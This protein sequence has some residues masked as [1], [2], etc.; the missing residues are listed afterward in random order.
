[1]GYIPA[2]D[3]LRALA[4]S[5]VILFHLWPWVLPGGYTGVDIFFVISGFVVTGSMTGRRFETLG[6]FLTYFYARRL[7]RIMPALGA[8]LIAAILATNLFVPDAWLSRSVPQTGIAAFFGLSN[9]A[10]ATD[11]DTYFGPQAGY[12]PFTHTWSLGVE[13]QFYLLFPFLLYPY[14]RLQARI[15]ERRLLWLVGGLTLGSFAIAAILLTQPQRFAFYLIF[16]RFW[17]LGVGMLLCLTLDR[18]RPW[19]GTLGATQRG[20]LM[21]ASLALIGAGLAMPPTGLFPFPLAL[22]P[23]LGTAGLIATV[24]ALPRS[25][26]TRVFGFRPFVVVGQLSY[27][28]YLWHWPVFVL[29][30]WTIGLETLPLALAAL[31]LAIALATL[32]YYFIEQPLRTNSRIA[33]MPRPLVVKGALACVAG[34]GLAGLLIFLLHDRIS[35]SV[36]SDHRAWYAETNRTL[37]PAQTHCRVTE[38]VTSFA[39]GKVTSWTPSQCKMRPAGFSVFA[40]GDSHNTAYAPDYRQLAADLGVTVHSWFRAGC[41]FLRL[42]DAIVAR[43]KCDDYDAALIAEMRAKAKPGDVIFLPGLRVARLINQFVNDHDID[44]A[45]PTSV[46]PQTFAATQ[47]TLAQLAGTGAKIVFEAPKPLFRSPPFRCSDWFNRNNPI[48]R[49][50]LTIARAELEA[51]RRPVLDAM[52]RLADAQPAL[53]VWDPFTLLCPGDECDAMPGG[54]PLFFDGDHLSGS[55]NDLVYPSLRDAIVRASG[56]AEAATAPA[57]SPDRSLIP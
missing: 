8:M 35:L 47:A 32:S 4:V 10:L 54:V 53:A 43:A 21:L 22:L 15:S 56:R 46:S 9:V 12:N 45:M 49:G 11:N 19:I 40:I 23:V 30:R 1:L 57:A 51:R 14:Q 52:N 34:A 17:E 38:D 37:D 16:P 24:R 18:W 29:F 6:N 5:S 25:P 50:G 42:N 41:P 44:N 36:T 3:G 7:V 48:C 39:G 13:E 31:G 27:S 33:A 2:V 28:L 55:G 20:G 26:A